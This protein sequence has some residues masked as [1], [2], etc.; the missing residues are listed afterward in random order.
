MFHDEQHSD[1]RLLQMPLKSLYEKSAPLT[2][3]DPFHV[4]FH[5][6]LPFSQILLQLFGRHGQSQ[7]FN[8]PIFP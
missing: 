6:S 1:G 3:N 4:I 2:Q 7:L 8:M 5:R